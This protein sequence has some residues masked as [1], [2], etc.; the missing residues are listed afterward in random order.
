[1]EYK[2][3]DSDITRY[4]DYL[5]YDVLKKQSDEQAIYNAARSK[6]PLKAALNTY[7]KNILGLKNF[8]PQIINELNNEKSH[9][10]YV[11]KEALIKFKVIHDELVSTKEKLEP[12]L[13]EIPPSELGF[14]DEYKVM[15]VKKNVYD[16]F[17]FPKIDRSSGN[18]LNFIDFL[19]KNR[20][21]K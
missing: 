10:Q 6:S 15:D 3:S 9:I 17:Y 16:K 1:M 4:Y 18:E 13:V 20:K 14:T 7:F 11:I 5:C 19:E 8:Y 21:V 2:L 12:N